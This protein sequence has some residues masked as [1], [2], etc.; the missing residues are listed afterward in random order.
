MRLFRLAPRGFF[1]GLCLAGLSSVAGATEASFFGGLAQQD[2][3]QA[4]LDR[5]SPEQRAA[6]DQQV[7]REISLARR[8][9]VVAFARTFSTRRPPSEFEAAGLEALTPAEIENLDALV[10]GALAARPVVALTRER[11]SMAAIETVTNRPQWR[12]IMS[13]T[14]GRSSGGGEF[15]GGSVTSIYDDPDRGFAAAL[16]IGRYRGDGVYFTG[17]RHCRYG[18]GGFRDWHR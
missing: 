5:L 12:G 13:V 11:P 9:G 6:L 2:R 8:G 15:Y 4:G 16:T 7:G 1:L 10:A 14:Y 17:G 3:E 18:R